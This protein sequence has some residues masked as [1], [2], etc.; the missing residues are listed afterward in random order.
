MCVCACACVYVTFTT[1]HC[2]SFL[3]GLDFLHKTSA[4]FESLSCYRPFRQRIN[5]ALNML[6]RENE[7]KKYV[8]CWSSQ[9]RSFIV[10]QKHIFS[11]LQLSVLCDFSV[12]KYLSLQLHLACVPYY[13]EDP[14]NKTCASTVMKVTFFV[15][16]KIYARSFTYFCLHYLT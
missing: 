9:H 12:F 4:V 8:F 13:H 16:K 1:P 5:I 15:R 2:S 6:L 7:K 11:R 10:E 14:E 3:S